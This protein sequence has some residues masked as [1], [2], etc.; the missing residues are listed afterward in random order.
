[1]KSSK[2]DTRSRAWMLT[3]FEQPEGMAAPRT[4]ADIAEILTGLRWCGQ[5]E[6]GHKKHHRHWQIYAEAKN[7]LRFSTW[8]RLCPDAHVEPREGS[9]QQ[10][11][12]Y[13]TKEDT[14][15]AGPFFH[16]I[17]PD[18]HDR[19]GKRTDLEEISKRILSGGESVSDLLLDP[20]ISTKLARCLPWA[21]SLEQAK[22]DKRAQRYRK[23]PR[24]VTV[25]YLWGEPGIGK[26]HSVLMSGIDVFEPTY[27]PSGGWDDYKG[28]DTILFDEFSGQ[29]ELWQMN[30]WLNGYPNTVLRA[31]YHNFVACYHQVFIVSNDPPESFYGGAKSWLRRLTCVEHAHAPMGY[32]MGLP[33]G[34]LHM[35][36]PMASDDDF[37][38]ELNEGV[39]EVQ[40]A[41]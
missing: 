29:V 32:V 17:N 3:V 19:S 6:E 20:G 36:E 14:R 8:K 40:S 21:K 9:K 39:E 23:E 5:L 15:V 28:Q 34:L 26:T 37:W 7:A 2:K 25:F 22:V 18:D 11:I 24:D 38:N 10:A 31:R 35:S 30:R 13:V 33:S 4:E 12:A 1:M 16:G 41:V 27:A